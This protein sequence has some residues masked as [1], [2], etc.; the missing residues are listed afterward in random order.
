MNPFKYSTNHHTGYKSPGFRFSFHVRSISHRF[1][2]LPLDMK[3]DPHIRR[4]LH[5]ESPLTVFNCQCIHSARHAFNELRN[6][7]DFPYWA[8]TEFRIRDREDADRIIPLNLN[9]PQSHM[10]DVMMK[11]RHNLQPSIYVITKTIRS[12]GL[13]TA[14][15]AYNLW[16]QTYHCLNNS[17]TCSSNDINLHQLK[18]NVC[19]FLGRDTV[20]SEKWLYLPKTDARAF[21]NTFRSPHFIRGINIGFVHFADMGKWKDA[22]GQLSRQVY[23]AS[24]SA[25]LLDHNTL[26]VLEGNI[27]KPDKFRIENHRQFYLNIDERI[28]RMQH[29]SNNPYFLDHVAR[30]TL[31]DPRIVHIDFESGFSPARRIS[32]PLLSPP[33][34]GRGA[35][36]FL[37]G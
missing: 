28:W 6:Q 7:Y 18:E 35:S 27:P 33:S 5:G 17:F 8:I 2:F 37:S 3:H 1:L 14:V 24:T 11:R 22:D 32:I 13:T 12:C 30:A 10:I 4:L 15:Q 34:G 16:L 23:T 9:I 19:R 36:T 31:P 26:I 25:V 20:P 29:L 21:F